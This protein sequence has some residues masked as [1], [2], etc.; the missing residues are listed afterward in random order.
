MSARDPVIVSL[1]VSDATALAAL[2]LTPRQFRDFVR[3]HAIPFA[4][5]KGRMLVRAD[6]L[7]EAID[8]LSGVDR[9][10]LA[11]TLDDDTVIAMAARPRRRRILRPRAPDQG[12]GY[13]P[14]GASRPRPE[15]TT[16]PQ[17]HSATEAAARAEFGPAV[18]RADLAEEAASG[19]GVGGERA[20]SAREG[21]E[22]P[23]PARGAPRAKRVGSGAVGGLSGGRH[24]S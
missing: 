23:G 16:Q 12:P 10:S 9:R 20:R 21:A 5:V 7:L 15:G 13:P 22:P 2:G 14:A 3:E 1:V 17:T 19:R 6:R 8:R 18:V 11:P 24:A 4:R